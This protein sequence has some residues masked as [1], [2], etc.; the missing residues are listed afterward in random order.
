MIKITQ[1]APDQFAEIGKLVVEVYSKLEG[2]FSKEEQP[3]YYDMLSNVG[4]LTEKDSIDILTAKSDG[5]LLGAVVYIDDMKDYGSGG[6]ATSEKNAAGFRLLA[7]S[8]DARGQGIGKK[9]TIACIE[10]AKEHGREQMI[11]HTTEAM[12]LAWGMYEKLGFE[13]SEDLDFL[14]QGFPV[15]GFRLKF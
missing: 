3:A 6:V 5:L 13:R 4:T 11:I 8:T 7:V 1:A 12:K 10:K 9:L 14:Q 15:Y 2:F